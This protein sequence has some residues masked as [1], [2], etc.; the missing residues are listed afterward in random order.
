MRFKK[1]VNILLF[2]FSALLIL[3]G[4]GITEHKIVSKITFGLLDKANAFKLHE[5]LVIPFIVLMLIHI[6][7]AIRRVIN[8]FR[9][10]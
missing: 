3:S 1:A 9:H 4:Y 5:F 8:K 6:W 7:P 2:I 10:D